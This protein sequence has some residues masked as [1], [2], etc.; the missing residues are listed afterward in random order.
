[1]KAV[2]YNRRS[3]PDKLVYRDVEKPLPNDD[4]VLIKI[5]AVSVNA[6]DYRSMKM[7]LINRLAMDW[8]EL[9][10]LSQKGRRLWKEGCL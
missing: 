10:K 9:L 3:S 5:L 2:V 8:K 7:G 1:M 6:A 4:K